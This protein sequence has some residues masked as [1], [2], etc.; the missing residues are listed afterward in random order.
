MQIKLRRFSIN[1]FNILLG[2]IPNAE[3]LFQFAG[4]EFSFPLTLNQVES[5]WLRYPER[6]MYSAFL[7]DNSPYA[8]GE[9]IPQNEESVRLGRILIG[10]PQ[11]RGKG[12]GLEFVKSLIDQCRIDFK[13]TSVD[14]NVLSDNIPAIRCY[15]RLGF[16]FTSEPEL[17]LLH[18]GT[19]YRIKRMSTKLKKTN[20]CNA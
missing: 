10:D 20:F 13:V 9:I 15:Q 3:F 11:L 19:E 16:R 6:K 2:W 12:L 18:E 17:T 7:N 8:F 4:S 5:Y 14:L 1:H